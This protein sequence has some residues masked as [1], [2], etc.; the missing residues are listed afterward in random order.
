MIGIIPTDTIYGIVAPALDKASVERIY[1][2]R[3]R[4]LKKPMIILIGSVNDLAR[5]GVTT[6]PAV[7]KIL[8]N[9]WPGQVSVVLPCTAKK[10]AYLHRGTKTLAFRL[11]KPAW[12]REFIKQTGPLV[13]PSANIQGKSPA[14]TIR[15]AKKYFGDRVDLYIDA[16]KLVSK[17]ST[18]IKIE[19]GKVFLLRQGSVKLDNLLK[20]V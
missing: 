3:K 13:A 5:F 8:K 17:P 4:D 11:P 2:L 12:L 15:A 16:G 9:V 6:T 7:K 18:I 1:R 14:Y 19:K 20:K 10:F